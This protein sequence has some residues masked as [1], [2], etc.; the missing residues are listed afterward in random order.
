MKKK[1]AY[2][3]EFILRASGI[4]LS[5]SFTSKC[6]VLNASLINNLFSKL[7]LKRGQGEKLHSVSMSSKNSSHDPLTFLTRLLTCACERAFIFARRFA[8]GRRALGVK[9]LL[10]DVM[11]HTFSSVSML[12]IHTHLDADLTAFCPSADAPARER[13]K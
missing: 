10:D 5:K 1:R 2:I 13:K 11:M 3:F 8:P 7:P 12:A 4:S 9:S 6:T